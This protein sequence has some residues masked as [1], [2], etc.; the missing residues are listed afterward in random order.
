MVVY[1]TCEEVVIYHYIYHSMHSNIY[2]THM[3]EQE[4]VEHLDLQTMTRV[5]K[6][7]WKITKKK[8]TGTQLKLNRYEVFSVELKEQKLHMSCSRMRAAIQYNY[9]MEVKLFMLASVLNISQLYKDIHIYFVP[10][11]VAFTAVHMMFLCV[12]IYHINKY[13]RLKQADLNLK[14]P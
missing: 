11:V 4:H 6:N 2:N 10:S 8:E 7:S 13:V 9:E 1:P 3:I 14:D 5:N 12:D